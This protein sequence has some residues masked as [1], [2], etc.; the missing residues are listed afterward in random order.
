MAAPVQY[1][2]DLAFIKDGI[3]QSIDKTHKGRDRQYPPERFERLLELAA[4]HDQVRGDASSST[5]AIPSSTRDELRKTCLELDEPG[6]VA[7][8]YPGSGQRA[9]SRTRTQKQMEEMPALELGFPIQTDPTDDDQA[10][11]GI[12]LQFLVRNAQIQKPPL[13]PAGPTMISQHLNSTC[14]VSSSKGT[15]K[16]SGR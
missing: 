11:I 2:K 15:P 7:R 5:K 1:D 10:H 16:P 9:S 4:A 13:D 6:L 12:I 3:Y 14:S 8:L